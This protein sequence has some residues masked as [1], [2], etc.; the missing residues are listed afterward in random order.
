METRA[1]AALPTRGVWPHGIDE[2]AGFNTNG[3][4]VRAPAGAGM[5][6]ENLEVAGGNTPELDLNPELTATRL[7]HGGIGEGD[8]MSMRCRGD[9]HG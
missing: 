5:S 3:R 6:G 4:E 2:T 9:M 1:F 8:A 7:G